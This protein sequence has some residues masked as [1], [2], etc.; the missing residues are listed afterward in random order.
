MSFYLPTSWLSIAVALIALTSGI[1]RAGEPPAEPKC[2]A[3]CSV[4]SP[5]TAILSSSEIASCLEKIANQPV[6][7]PSLEL[8]TLLFH[9]SRVIPHLHE[10]GH[11]PLKSEQ[12]QFLKRELART[13]AEVE[14]RIVDA[15]GKQRMRFERQVPIGE[16]Q[17][18]H[19]KQAQGFAPPEISFTIHRVGLNHLWSRL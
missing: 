18:L 13:H 8:E 2:A 5:P 16:K 1:A 10:K 4:A 9:A 15:D 19:A 7:S 17:H 12:A 11:G 6:G 14:L 3:G